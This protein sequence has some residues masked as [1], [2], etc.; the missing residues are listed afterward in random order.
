MLTTSSSSSG[1]FRVTGSPDEHPPS[2]NQGQNNNRMSLSLEAPASASPFP[3]PSSSFLPPPTP[4]AHEFA[5]KPPPASSVAAAARKA[6]ANAFMLGL[7]INGTGSGVNGTASPNGGA[8]LSRN[9]SASATA[10]APTTTTGRKWNYYHRYHHLDLFFSQP[11]V[12]FG[13]GFIVF[14]CDTPYSTSRH[15]NDDDAVIDIGIRS[16]VTFFLLLDGSVSYTRRIH[17]SIHIHIH[18]YLSSYPTTIYINHT[19]KTD[20]TPPTLL[21]PIHLPLLFF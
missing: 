5:M 1:F 9:G 11:S 17:A 7:G 16:F 14:Q 4:G 18:I 10:A 2:S 20:L 13:V 19:L 3:S 15:D 12:E 6:S 8:S 21:I